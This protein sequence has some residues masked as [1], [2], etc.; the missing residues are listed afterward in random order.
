MFCTQYTI[1]I[2]Y[3]KELYCLHTTYSERKA[4]NKNKRRVHLY[5]VVFAWRVA[6][7][8]SFF[9]RPTE[10]NTEKGKAQKQHTSKTS[11]NHS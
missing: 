5:C 10:S 8:T 3:R 9:I 2:S 1:G 11:L 6:F 4:S 7:V